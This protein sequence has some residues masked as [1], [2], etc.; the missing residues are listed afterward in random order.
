MG[1]DTHTK[2]KKKLKLNKFPSHLFTSFT[3]K[4]K[5]LKSLIQL[6]NFLPIYLHHSY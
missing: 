1:G 6:F 4:K 3:H 5:S 2:K